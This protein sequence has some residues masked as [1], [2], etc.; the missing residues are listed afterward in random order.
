MKDFLKICGT[1][2]GLIGHIPSIGEKI[3][4]LFTVVETEGKKQNNC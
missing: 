4:I 3:D 1:M 2:G